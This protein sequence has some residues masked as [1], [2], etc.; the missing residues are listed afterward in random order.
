[1]SALKHY[2]NIWT[3][4]HVPKCSWNYF[5][6]LLSKSINRHPLLSY[7]L[8]RNKELA[9]SC[10]SR[11][12]LTIAYLFVLNVLLSDSEYK[13]INLQNGNLISSSLCECFVLNSQHEKS[14]TNFYFWFIT[15]GWRSNTL[16][17]YLYSSHNG[18]WTIQEASCS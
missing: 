3:G 6:L 12:Y 4:I 14:T 5:N 11:T 18:L 7:I 10:L 9:I 15:F 17:I 2:I 16:V 1:M 13:W 8:W